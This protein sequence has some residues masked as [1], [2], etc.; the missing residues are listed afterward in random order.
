MDPDGR[1]AGKLF[2]DIDDLAKDFALN[3]NDDSIRLNRELGASIYKTKD[4][5]YYYTIPY[6]GSRTSVHPTELAGEKRFGV[7]HTHTFGF[8]MD[9]FSDTD[10]IIAN[11]ENIISYIVL[12]DGGLL[13]YDPS[14]PYN[15]DKNPTEILKKERFPNKNNYDQY[16]ENELITNPFSK[17]WYYLFGD[18]K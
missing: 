1:E 4:N 18:K 5:Q 11:K 13:K 9:R 12:S 14:K 16:P 6:K 15:P 7:I 2:N 8:Q 10:I 3:Y 17:F